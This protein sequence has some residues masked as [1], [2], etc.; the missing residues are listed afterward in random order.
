MPKPY[1]IKII[2][3]EEFVYDPEV[4][5]LVPIYKEENGTVYKYDYKKTHCYY[6]DFEEPEYDED[7][8]LGFYGKERERYLKEN[9]ITHYEWL[10]TCLKLQPH[11]IEIDKKC[12]EMEDS[13]MAE[14]AKAEGV[15][16]ELK[17]ADMFEWT[18]RMNNIKNRVREV[19]LNELVYTMTD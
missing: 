18:A 8:T 19:V 1:E 4:K 15:T 14:Y 10:L 5:E 2:D 16:A 17:K 13:L 9:R 3:G 12:N 11:L 7:Y 6:P